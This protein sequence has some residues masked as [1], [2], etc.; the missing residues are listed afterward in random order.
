[1]EK[2]IPQRK[3]QALH[4]YQKNIIQID[5]SLQNHR[6]SKSE[7]I[8]DGN[9]PKHGHEKRQMPHQ[10]EGF[11]PLKFFAKIIR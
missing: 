10:S 5:P 1:M 7:I 9:Q 2:K 11:G 4:N 6:L 3:E 8:Q